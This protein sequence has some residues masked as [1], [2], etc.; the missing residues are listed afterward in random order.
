[1]IP[2]NAL[3]NLQFHADLTES[4]VGNGDLPRHFESFLVWCPFL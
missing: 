2:T 4:Y 3:P 1:M